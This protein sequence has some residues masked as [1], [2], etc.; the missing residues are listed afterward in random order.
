MLCSQNIDTS[1]I[2]Q[3]EIL[4][5]KGFFSLSQIDTKLKFIKM[6]KCLTSKIS[7]HITQTLTRYAQKYPVVTL[8]IGK[9]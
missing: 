1:E 2:P 6:Y 8:F 3:W 5:V 9:F 4:V 7:P